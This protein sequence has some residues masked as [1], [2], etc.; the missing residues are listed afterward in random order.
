MAKS[1][2][3]R[4]DTGS[5]LPLPRCKSGDCP[6]GWMELN[7]IY[8]RTPPDLRLWDS[9]F[10]PEIGREIR[11][12]HDD[13]LPWLLRSENVQY[14]D[15]AKAWEVI[16]ERQNQDV[17]SRRDAATD[18]LKNKTGRSFD[19]PEKWVQWCQKNRSNLVLSEDGLKQVIKRRE[20]PRTEFRGYRQGAD[21]SG[22]VVDSPVRPAEWRFRISVQR[23]SNS[24]A[25]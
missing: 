13:F 14:A 23:R 25:S 20:F 15:W 18:W 2:S 6:L 1:I 24:R 21:R 7:E 11:W 8:A 22:C 16:R 19:S 12:H 4:Q 3:A 10:Q 9:R 17:V 5:K